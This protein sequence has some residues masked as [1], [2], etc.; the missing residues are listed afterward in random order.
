M[1]KGGDCS[2]EL[3][4]I[5]TSSNLL[6]SSFVISHLYKKFITLFSILY[7]FLGFVDILFILE[8]EIKE[9]SEAINFEP[10]ILIP[11]YLQLFNIFPQSI[12]CSSVTSLYKIISNIS[13]SPV[14]LCGL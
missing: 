3:K 14:L 1:S 11:L 2:S 5:L 10:T 9:P 7:A 8:A 6:I 4:F 12:T 13:I